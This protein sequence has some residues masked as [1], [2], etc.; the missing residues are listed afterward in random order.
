MPSALIKCQCG[1]GRTRPALTSKGKVA[2]YIAGH[3]RLVAAQRLRGTVIAVFPSTGYPMLLEVGKRARAMHRLIA[4][5]ALG[6]PLPAGV[7]I[8]H[9]DDDRANYAN[10]NL[11]IC[12]NKDYHRLLHSRARIVRAGG[13]PETQKICGSCH[14]LLYRT[15]FYASKE[16]KRRDGL[17]PRCIDC[18][19]KKTHDRYVQRHAM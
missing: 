2:R 4:E 17:R 15:C 7:E 9:I 10:S 12:E 11:V 13:D 3:N 16:P 5:R 8:H 1:C 19:S 6:K 14:R 18:W